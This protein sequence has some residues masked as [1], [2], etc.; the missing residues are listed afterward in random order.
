MPNTFA[1]MVFF[2][3]PLLTLV[4]VLTCRPASAVIGSMLFG[5]LLLPSRVIINPPLLPS[6]DKES[7]AVLTLGVCWLIGAL[8]LSPRRRTGAGAG[9][10]EPMATPEGLLPRAMLLRVV[11]LVFLFSPLATVFLNGDRLTFGPRTIQGLGLYDAGNAIVNAS[12]MALAF[13]LG[14]KFL[15]SADDHRIVLITFVVA[16]VV[17]AVPAL[18]EVRMYPQFNAWVYGFRPTQ[19]SMVARL[20]GW[21]PQVFLAH[22]LHLGTLLAMFAG[23]AAALFRIYSGPT[24]AQALVAFLFILATLVLAKSTGAILFGFLFSMVIL[25]SGVRTQ[26]VFAALVAAFVMTYPLARGS[27]LLTADRVIAPIAPIVQVERIRSLRFRLLNEDLLMQR[28]LE[29]PVFGWGHWGRSRVY[30]PVTGVDQTVT[31][32]SWVIAIGAWGTVGYVGRFGMLLLPIILLYR[33]R[34]H[35]DMNLET[36]GLAIILGMNALDLLPNSSQ[37]PL[38]FLLSGALAGRAEML[39]RSVSAKVKEAPRAPRRAPR[40]GHVGAL[41]KA[42][43]AVGRTL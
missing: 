16:G 2:V 42:R 22:G 8:T 37:F 12:V 21:R 15:H 24:R 40:I 5:L 41:S 14:R 35:A 19:H 20:G 25:F 3:W 38:T 11:V 18:Y 43:R 30:D 34:R 29:R 13:L 1:Y 17:Y 9:V 32:G 4:L 23:A 27:G 26:L 31:D 28:M 10:T 7:L 39:A 33:M 36:S 6:I